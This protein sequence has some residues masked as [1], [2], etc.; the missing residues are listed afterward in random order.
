[1][2]Y[3]QAQGLSTDDV[4]SICE[5]SDGTIWVGGE[6]GRLDAWSGTEFTSRPL[7][8]LPAGAAIRALSG[9][10]D[11]TIWVGT[12]AG[13]V[14]LEDGE[15]RR[16]TT[17]DGLADDSIECL[18]EGSDG[19]LWVGTKDGV[20]RVRQ[21]EIES[22]RPRD[23]LSQSTVHSLCEDHEGSLWVG[24]K[25]GLNQFVDRRTT[26]F[27]ASEGLPSN[28]TGPV[29]QDRDGTIWVGT[30]DAGLA[31]FDGRHF[32]VAAD[33][34][35][36][37][38]GN[39]VRALAEGEQGELWIGTDEGLCRMRDGR[40]VER[41]TVDEGLPSNS[42]QCLYRDNRNML[43]AGT[44]AGLAELRDSR[45][46]RPLGEPEDLSLP[47]AAMIA[48]GGGLLA[49]TAGGGLYHVVDGQFI[50]STGGG[51]PIRDVD[52]F[53]QD[54]DG[55]LWI[56]TRG[57]GLRLIDGERT[58]RFNVKDG[59]YDD[60]I[61]GI[62]ADK[63]DR[64]WMACSRGMFFVERVELRKFAAGE[65]KRL[66]STPFSP[67]D[68]Q[69]T[70][71]C[72]AAVQPAVS[73]MRDGRVWFSTIRGVL[74]IDP[75]HMRRRLPKP[76]VVVEEVK[77]NGQPEEPRQIKSLPPGRTNLDF[78]YTA[79]SFAS[80]T[81]IAFRYRLEGF[82]KD[83]V[84][85]G[86][87][88]EAFYTNLPPGSYRFRVAA[89]YLDGPS[90]TRVDAPLADDTFTLDGTS[91]EAASPVAF[92]LE[93]HFYQRRWFLPL[94]GGLAAL[95]GWI[96]Y[97]LRVRRIRAEWC[98]VLAERGRI[99]RELHDTLMQGFSGVTMQ[100]QALAARLPESPERRTLEEVVTDAGVC[101]RDARRSVAGLRSAAG[102]ES[103]LAEAIAEAARQITET[104]DVRLHLR[105]ARGPEG[106]AADVEY[107]LL[108]I[109]QEA[110][111]N[112]VKHAAAGA[113][114]VTLECTPR[115]LRLSVHDDGVGFKVEVQPSLPGHYGLIGMRERASRIGADLRLQSEPGSGT[116]VSLSLPAAPAAASPLN[117]PGHD[118]PK[119]KSPGQND[120]A[121]SST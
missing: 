11:G 40:I 44:A 20:S 50:A 74:V 9:A 105:L 79:L 25:H 120:V 104:H 77:V 15:E 5:A 42:V 16:F 109:A 118:P 36:G 51:P 43:W 65:V 34:E 96:A 53:Y 1:M 55:L 31:R 61:F 38:T 26:P 7:Q 92:T 57:G 64:L 28:D 112:A 98:A 84:D 110:L 117:V 69:R 29:F 6:S 35:N 73:K 24:T 75:R 70:V 12:T 22:F 32:S 41:F 111:A 89:R 19:G 2:V 106:L 66:A 113:I 103:G 83:W 62:V 95:A 121:E 14:R 68:A 97:R 33:A 48:H 17:A 13:L 23:G 119:C 4:W 63:E 18:A 87:R 3:R 58:F 21:D 102:G 99:A 46:T 88:R 10:G 101:L 108:R 86:G 100:M 30:L 54:A 116:T 56:G 94:A 49:A 85:A 60:E 37:L 93:P 91:T 114:D 27:T 39:T 107:D 72:Q 52:A 80:P 45:F 90:D 82:D 8:S 59:L 78:R 81:R 76:A 71:E 67:T 115:Q 47:I